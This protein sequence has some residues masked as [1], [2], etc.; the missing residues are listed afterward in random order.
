MPPHLLCGR[1]GHCYPKN[2]MNTTSYKS[3]FLL[4]HLRFFAQWPKSPLKM[5]NVIFFF[6]SISIAFSKLMLRQKMSGVRKLKTVSKCDLVKVIACAQL[7]YSKNKSYSWTL[8]LFYVWKSRGCLRNGGVSCAN[9][10]HLYVSFQIK[11]LLK[12]YLLFRQA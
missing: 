6:I 10:H 9:H 7:L 1:R 5:W 11:K 3:L 8:N 12:R 4:L 2:G